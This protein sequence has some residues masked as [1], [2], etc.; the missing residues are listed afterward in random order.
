M[1][2]QL[3]QRALELLQV[4]CHLPRKYFLCFGKYYWELYKLELVDEDGSVTYLGRQFVKH[5]IKEGALK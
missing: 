1:K 3:N 5:C 4:S 2:N